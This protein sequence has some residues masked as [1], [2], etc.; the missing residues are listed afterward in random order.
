MT[1]IHRWFRSGEYSLLSHALLPEQPRGTGVLIVPPFGWEDISSY[2]PLRF[3]ARTLAQNGF[4]VLRFDLPGT[5]DSSGDALDPGLFDAWVQ[6]IGDAA[7]ELRNLSGVERVTVAGLSL[8]ATLALLAAARGAAVDDLIL[9]GPSAT[10]RGLL[11]E[12]QA[13]AALQRTGHDDIENAPPHPFEGLDVGGFLIALE[14]QRA[15]ESVD[16]SGP[17]P[18][19]KRRVLILSRDDLPADK[20][21]IRALSSCDVH[22]RPGRGYSAMMVIPHEAVPPDEAGREILE[23][24]K[25]GPQPRSAI[26]VTPHEDHRAVESIYTF[27][28]SGNETFGIL[29]GPSFPDVC[30]LFLN[31]GATRHIGPNRMWVEAARRWAA[32]GVPSLRVDLPGIGESDGDPVLGVPE[33]YQQRMVEHV[34]SA[35]QTLERRIGARRFALVGLCSGAFWALHAAARNRSIRSAV[36][37]NPRLYTWDPEV[38]RV[39]ALRRAVKG[40]V[41]W[42]DWRRVAGGRVQLDDIKR[43]VADGFRAR[44]ARD[45]RPFERQME[46]F[47]SLCSEL[48]RHQTRVTLLFSEG[49]P[50]LREMQ[51]EAALPPET[52]ARIRAVRA[53]AGGHA[54][55]PLWVQK[56]VH[57]FIDRELEVALRVAH[58]PRV[59]ET[60]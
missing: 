1:P 57:E 26:A 18:V 52:G 8:G 28:D 31:P 25:S 40:L 60:A 43:M 42:R 15:L 10:G 5:G 19:S 56:M 7:R 59:A 39:R 58:P 37:L 48:D 24:L 22:V 29:A 36:L 27:A 12:L 50:L 13:F 47:A 38:D 6:S 33:L 35:M 30:L 32:R 44:S 20:R 21:L 14:T 46:S 23:F 11:R 2:R 45:R 51:D 49:E 53:P 55:R 41:T 17:L 34:E 3:L 4:P 54:F 9:W 16:F